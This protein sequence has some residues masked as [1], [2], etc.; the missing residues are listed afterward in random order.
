MKPNYKY[1]SLSE[2]RKANP[3]LYMQLRKR[4][5]L[6]RLCLDMGWKKQ[7]QK[8]FGYWNI[9]ENCIKESKKRINRID[10]NR[11]SSGAYD[12]SVRNGWLE[13]IYQLNAW[14]LKKKKSSGYW[15]KE[16][17]IKES[18]KY[19]NR[20]DFNRNSSGAYDASV[21]NGWLE[22]IK[23]LRNWRIT[24]GYWTIKKN[25]IKESEKYNKKSEF[26]KNSFAAFKSAKNHGW[27][28]EICELRG[29]NQYLVNK[30]IQKPFGYWNKENCIKESKKRSGRNNFRINSF[31]AYDASI[32]NG[33]LDEIS[34]LN[35]W[36]KPNKQKPQHYWTKERCIEESKKRNGITEFNSKSCGAYKASVRNGWLGKIK[37]LNNW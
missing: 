18:E 36:K 4:G 3:N 5:E 22:E 12:A 23:E 1:K 34:E 6:E 27:L 10:F 13:E 26:K 16:N 25:C 21:R 20:I 8:P 17:C 9:K 19:N 2:F 24:R 37:E 32:K 11:N 35:G 30:Q 29:W 28:D 31:G 15:N 7:L 33:W 14:D